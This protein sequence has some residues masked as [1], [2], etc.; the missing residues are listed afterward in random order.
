MDQLPEPIYVTLE[1]TV[2]LILFLLVTL[3]LLAQPWDLLGGSRVGLGSYSVESDKE[4][5][6]L[7]VLSYSVP[8][9]A[10]NLA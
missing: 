8:K 9:L 7:G 2:Y 4:A 6:L 1:Q 10:V 3:N 5:E